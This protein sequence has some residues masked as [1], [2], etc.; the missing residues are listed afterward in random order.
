M[1]EIHNGSTSAPPINMTA[2][3]AMARSPFRTTVEGNGSQSQSQLL[4]TV[5]LRVAAGRFDSQLFGPADPESHEPE[6]VEN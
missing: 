5:R 2:V 6:A 4:W 3:P 1:K